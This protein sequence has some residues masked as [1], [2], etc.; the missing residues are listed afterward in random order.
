MEGLTR[1]P[2]ICVPTN[3]RRSARG[4]RLGAALPYPV[5]AVAR[6]PG[7][8]A[9][10]HIAPATLHY[11]GADGQLLQAEPVGPV[12]PAQTALH[13]GEWLSCMCVCVWPPHQ[14]D[15]DCIAIT[16]TRVVLYAVCRPL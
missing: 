6:Q 1:T 8:Q 9:V 3:P 4:E 2:S 12:L 16:H 13:S 11:A 10:L 14:V 7:L 5:A 15:S